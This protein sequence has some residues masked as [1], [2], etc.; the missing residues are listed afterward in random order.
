MEVT[1]MKSLIL[2]QVQNIQMLSYRPKYYLNQN[3]ILYL[4]RMETTVVYLNFTDVNH[5]LT[6]ASIRLHISTAPR[7]VSSV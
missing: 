2:D 1:P 6:V 5:G 3:I 7:W 4:M